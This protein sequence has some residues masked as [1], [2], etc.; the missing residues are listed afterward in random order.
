MAQ[1]RNPPHRIG[2]VVRHNEGRRATTGVASLNEG[3]MLT[4]ND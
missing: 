4:A 2:L 3:V 1:G